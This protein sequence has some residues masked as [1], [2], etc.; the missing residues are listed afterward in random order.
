MTTGVGTPL[1]A[2]ARAGRA[3]VTA[4][5]WLAG[6][7]DM[8]GRPARED[9]QSRLLARVGS[10]AAIAALVLYLAWRVRF[11]L[12]AGGRDLTAALVLLGFEAVPLLVLVVRAFALWSTDSEAP[13]PVTEVPPGLRPVVLIT[14]RDEPAQV[15]TATVAAACRLR[16]VHQTWVLDEGERAWVAEMCARYGARHVPRRGDAGDGS[17]AVNHALALIEQETA[18]GRDPL[19]VIAVLDADHVPLPTFLSAT[20]GWFADPATAVVQAPQSYYNAGAFGDDGDTG[21]QGT[22]FHVLLP[23]KQHHDT[24]QHDGTGP[25]W[26]GSTALLRVQALTEV[27][28][29]VP[30]PD[31]EEIAT[32]LALQRA[33]W[34]TRYHHQ[35]LAVGLAPQTP[36]RY[37]QEQRRRALGSVRLMVGDRLWWP[38]RW[39]S[40]RAYRQY[41]TTAGWLADFAVLL[42]FLVPVGVLLSGAVTSTVRPVALGLAFGLM[43]GVRLG[44]AKLV[45]RGRRHWR[46]EVALSL[47]RILAA[48]DCVW[49][50]LTRRSPRPSA[51]PPPGAGR[52]LGRVPSRLWVL[53]GLVAAV[54]SY[55]ALGL[56][57][58]VPWRSSEASIVAPGLWLMVATTVLFLTVRRIRDPAYATTRRV[59]YRVPVH[60]PVR[61][62]GTWGELVN[63][64]VGGVAVRLPPHALPQSGAVQL[65]LP[66][67][68][69]LSLQIVR[70][71]VD[72][73][74]DEVSFRVT[75]GDWAT[76]RELGLW[77][78]HTPPGVIDGLLLGA[79]AVAAVDSG[80]RSRRPRLLCEHV[81][82]LAVGAPW[83]G[84][85]R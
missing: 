51:V 73:D 6:W 71:A 84:S 49:W 81:D 44:A 83:S 22:L 78:F 70:V 18:E 79:P 60:A 42:G 59:A 3:S 31:A 54:L 15:L 14:T 64:S 7:A 56:T 63:V 41:L 2:R 21:E 53:L 52:V 11:T 29:V 40:W 69:D 20:L 32:T 74:L 68:G 25:Y 58:W 28:G 24:G 34:R 66:A 48:T 12:P 33:G 16:P 19:D 43:C 82:P 55:A 8:L 57:R 10:V 37:L 80:F 46:T 85:V 36:D 13:E 17:G 77:L 23:A 39:R 38:G 35:T 4:D 75:P 30:A 76:F 61:V 67:T 62:N 47:L 50:L 9:R 27:D 1:P 26:L 65:R 72:D 5:A 45:Y